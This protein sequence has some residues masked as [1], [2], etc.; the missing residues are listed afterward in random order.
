MEIPEKILTKWKSLYCH[1][2]ALY[3]TQA[4]EKKGISVHHNTVKMKL[5]RP[6]KMTIRMFNIIND[7]YQNK[8]ESLKNAEQQMD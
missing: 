1:G 8:K 3:I 4:A 7:Y 6:E 2:D 5:K